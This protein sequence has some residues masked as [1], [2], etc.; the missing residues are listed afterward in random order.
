MT[1]MKNGNEGR[2]LFVE[3]TYGKFTLKKEENWTMPLELNL[4]KKANI[5]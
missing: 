2:I 5:Q 1:K 4:I 3:E